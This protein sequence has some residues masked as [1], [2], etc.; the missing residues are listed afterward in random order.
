MITILINLIVK[1]LGS[2]PDFSLTLSIVGYSLGPL[3]VAN[4]IVL[5]LISSS[6]GISYTTDLILIYN[7]P[8]FFVSRL[9]MGVAMIISLHLISDGLS[10]AYTVHRLLIFMI[11]MP[12]II[13][14]AIII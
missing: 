2:E 13:L 14:L 12:L 3:I 8:S 4:I 6:G 5:P 11:L 7:S 9:I 10:K 1:L